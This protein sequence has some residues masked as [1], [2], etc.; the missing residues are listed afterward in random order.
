MNGIQT[1]WKTFPDAPA[2]TSVTIKDYIQE[3]YDTWAKAPTY[4]LLI[5]DY[6]A[7][8]DLVAG[9][10]ASDSVT[11]IALDN[12]FSHLGRFSVDYRDHFGESPRETL[13]LR[14][15]AGRRRAV[16]ERTDPLPGNL[17]MVD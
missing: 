10:S 5:G 6:E 11:R 12:G 1:V 3:A 14:E 17:C 7:C 13:A 4:V 2:T 15:G 16:A 8:Q 9:G